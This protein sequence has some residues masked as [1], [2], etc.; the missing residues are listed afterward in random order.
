MPEPIVLASASATRARL[1]R[2]A[3]V[4]IA[5]EPANIDEATIKRT[6]R[7]DH[8]AATACA[9]AL[10]DAKA[11]RI[12]ARHPAALVIGADQILVAGDDWLDKPR[13]SDDA[14]VQLRALRGRSHTLATAACVVCGG[15]R[16]WQAVTEP[17]LTMRNFSEAFL[18]AYLAAEAAAVLASVGAYRL[19]ARGA[20]LF[21]RV[22]GDHFA[23]LG[24][25]LIELL[26]FLRARGALPS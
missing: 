6:Y 19:E 3:G 10:A 8:S 25:P 11:R 17:R 15:E 16:L 26:Q 2:A 1:L 20:Q 5:I 18:D 21:A 4:E 13:D 23:I 24:L 14:R 7:N 12:A 9:L 22:E